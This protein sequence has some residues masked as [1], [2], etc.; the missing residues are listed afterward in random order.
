MALVLTFILYGCG[1][2][3]NIIKGGNEEK[4]SNNQGN[5]DNGV[6]G[7]NMTQEAEN[8][9]LQVIKVDEEA[10]ITIQNSEFY[11]AL[12]EVVESD[13]QMGDQ[14]DISLYPYSV[15]EMDDGENSA[16]FLVINRLGKP[17]KNFVFDFTFGSQDGE[18]I[19]EQM[20]VD[21]PEEFM[22]VLEDAG[23]IPILLDI[24]ETDIDL[25]LSLEQ[26][27]IFMELDNVGI[28]FVE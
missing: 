26:E 2:D 28:D 25:F 10:G 19:Y 24:D 22:G 8:L 7:D 5:A 12:L 4:E 17:I 6:G 27:D 21:L 15:M 13:P 20:E 3:E 16:L 11:Q 1:N 14:G 9:T 18:Y 23:V